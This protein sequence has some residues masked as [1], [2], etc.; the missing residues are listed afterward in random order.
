[1]TIYSFHQLF[2]LANVRPLSC[3][4]LVGDFLSNEIVVPSQITIRQMTR[5]ASETDL[6]LSKSLIWLLTASRRSMSVVYTGRPFFA[7]ISKPIAF[8][9]AGFYQS[10]IDRALRPHPRSYAAA[11][12]PVSFS[13]EQMER[14]KPSCQPNVS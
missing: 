7:N 14:M 11:G 10:E 13:T 2:S 4:V 12:N 9:A 6:P 3:T 1:M 8:C 5:K